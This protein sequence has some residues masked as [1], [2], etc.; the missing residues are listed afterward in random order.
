M[1]EDAALEAKTSEGAVFHGF[2]RGQEEGEAT[3]CLNRLGDVSQICLPDT[4]RLLNHSS[5]RL[6]SNFHSSKEI[7]ETFLE[8]RNGLETQVVD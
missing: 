6:T 1:S 2:F 3:F 4:S 5:W 7:S 8:L